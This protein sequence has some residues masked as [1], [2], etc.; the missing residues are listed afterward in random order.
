MADEKRCSLDGPADR[1]LAHPAKTIKTGNYSL[2]PSIGQMDLD[3]PTQS[4]KPVVLA[5][6][7]NAR[8]PLAFAGFAL[9]T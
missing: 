2:I 6:P 3:S 8:H 5:S 9:D 7:V 4:S 1:Y